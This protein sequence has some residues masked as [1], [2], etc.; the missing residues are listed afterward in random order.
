MMAGWAAARN[1]LALSSVAMLR[2]ICA[3]TLER[4]A[5][6]VRFGSVP[7]GSVTEDALAGHFEPVAH[8]AQARPPSN[9]RP[10]LVP[11]PVAWD[12]SP[13]VLRVEAKP[14]G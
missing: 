10:S 2:R 11:E 14:V 6:A 8:Q 7:I 3:F 1:F 12:V 5:G 13:G 4:P 9:R